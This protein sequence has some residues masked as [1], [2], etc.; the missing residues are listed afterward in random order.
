MKP[1]IFSVWAKITASCLLTRI[2]L[3]C[4]LA[5]L[6]KFSLP[7]LL[8]G[9][10]SPQVFLILLLL[11]FINKCPRHLHIRYINHENKLD[12]S[13]YQ[14][15][16][17]KNIVSIHCK[18]ITWLTMILLLNLFH[19][20]YHLLHCISQQQSHHSLPNFKFN[21]WFSLSLM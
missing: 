5:T 21:R 4:I 18:S 13:L 2:V 19:S 6:V 3:N 16:Y 12:E 17:K 20:N 9:L 11:W 15:N 14:W 1:V 7:F 8:S 10:C